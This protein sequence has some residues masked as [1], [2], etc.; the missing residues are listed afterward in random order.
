MAINLNYERMGRGQLYVASHPAADLGVTNTARIHAYKQLFYVVGDTGTTLTGGVV[1]F[2]NLKADGLTIQIK[3]NV[4]ESEPNNGPKHPI[5][6]AD[7][8]IE[9]AFELLDVDATNVAAVFGCS[10]SELISI[11]AASGKAGRKFA[12]VGGQSQFTQKTIMYRMPSVLT[13]GQFDNVIFPRCVIYGDTELK[14]GKNAGAISLKVKAKAMPDNWLVNSD[15]FGES[16][17][18]DVADTAA[19]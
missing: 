6:I 3:Q 10:A 1:E 13:P 4:V 7:T 11:A 2:A 12:L 18:W 19:L 14:L 8:D 9:L 15:G 17:V 16:M 5:G